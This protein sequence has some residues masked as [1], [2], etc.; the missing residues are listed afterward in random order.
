LKDGGKMKLT[1]TSEVVRFAGEIEEKR[2]KFYQ[3]LSEKYPRK[4]DIFLSFAKENRKNKV[5]IQRAYQGV[6]SDALETGFSFKEFEVGD[7]IFDADLEENIDL[8]AVLKKAVQI[9]DKAYRFFSDAA[10][11]SK[12]LLADIPRT[13]E[14]IARKTDERK[15]KLKLFLER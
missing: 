13:F 3:N 10:E 14:R 12:G 7:Y 15:R 9:E 4:K 6:V 2:E 5:S 8:S 11:K 1:T